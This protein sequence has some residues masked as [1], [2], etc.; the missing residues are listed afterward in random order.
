LKTAD[1]RTLAWE[2]FGSGPPLLCHPGGPGMSGIYFDGLPDLEAER[3]VLALDPRGTG[4][5]DPPADPRDYDLAAYAADVEAVR[6][7]LGLERLDYLGHS[8]GGFVGMTWASTYP[9]CVGHLVLSNTAPRFTD[10]VRFQSEA[11]VESYSGEP[12]YPDALA[13]LRAHQSGDFADSADLTALLDRRLPF[14]FPRWGEDEKAVGELMSR[15]GMNADALRHFNERVAGGMDLRPGLARVTVPVLVITGE[16]DPMGRES[17]QEIAA[18]L[19]NATV[20]VVPDAGH[21][22]FGESGKR[23]AWA[24]AILDYLNS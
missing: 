17:A 20:V 8:H 6:E 16:L 21:F 4:A 5:S 3:T 1:G 23:D 12:W 13:A 2:E 22:I 24:Q 14:Y 10:T 19:P 7:H 18:A 15:S 9:E 11:I